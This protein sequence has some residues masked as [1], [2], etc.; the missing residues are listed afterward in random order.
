MS[1]NCFVVSIYKSLFSNSIIELICVIVIAEDSM[2]DICMEMI[3]ILVYLRCFQELCRQ[4]F[5]GIKLDFVGDLCEHGK[6]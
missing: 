6:K 3:N 2:C 4:D 1:C 5:V